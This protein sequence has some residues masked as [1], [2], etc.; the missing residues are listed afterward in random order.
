MGDERLSTES[1]ETTA[2]PRG[3]DEV[4]TVVKDKIIEVLFDIDPSLIDRNKS[5]T[6]LGASSLD[7][8]DIALMAMEDLGLSFP[9][10]ELAGVQDIGGLVDLLWAKLHASAD[11]H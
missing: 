7:R 4:F 3:P 6:D 9:G 5:L 1:A 11:D 10:R 2:G 8:T